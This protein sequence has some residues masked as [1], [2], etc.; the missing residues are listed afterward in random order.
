MC[1][2]FREHLLFILSEEERTMGIRQRER[3]FASYPDV[4]SVEQMC[5]MLGGIGKRTAYA[6]LRDG[7]I[8]YMKIG[9]SFKIPKISIIEYLIGPD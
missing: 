6:L 8:R 3:L 7:E 5:T 9:K 4:V 1:P 2:V